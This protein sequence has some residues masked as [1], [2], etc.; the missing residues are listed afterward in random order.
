MS[1]KGDCCY[2]P[3]PLSSEREAEVC[4]SLHRFLHRNH[5]ARGKDAYDR[6]ECQ[7]VVTIDVKGITAQCELCGDIRQ[8]IPPVETPDRDASAGDDG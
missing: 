7:G 8:L 5:C 4:R 6:H 2:L 1:F 3:K